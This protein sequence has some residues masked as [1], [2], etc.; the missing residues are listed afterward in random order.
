[1]AHPLAL[2]TGPRSRLR[3][4]RQAMNTDGSEM[5]S[6]R[7][8]IRMI[9]CHQVRDLRVATMAVTT[10]IT[11]AIAMVMPAILPTSNGAALVAACAPA[12]GV[13]VAPSVMALKVPSPLLALAS[14]DLPIFSEIQRAAFL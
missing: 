3:S 5:T 14:A 11:A 1:M 7:P 4:L 2:S 9:H 13:V 12:A 8:T 10:P 6:I